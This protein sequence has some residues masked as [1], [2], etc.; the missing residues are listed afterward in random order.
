MGT[1]RSRRKRVRRKNIISAKLRFVVYEKAFHFLYAPFKITSILFICTL[2]L[3][4]FMNETRVGM[5]LFRTF[6]MYFNKYDIKLCVEF[7]RKLTI[8]DKITI[9][10]TILL[11][12]SILL[13]ISEYFCN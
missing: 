12:I 6:Q 2:Y 10:F 8:V 5:K 7:I 13:R 11:K 1:H 4:I 3:Y 9:N